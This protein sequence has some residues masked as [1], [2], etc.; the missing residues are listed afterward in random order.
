V[1]LEILGAIPCLLLPG[2]KEIAAGKE[3]WEVVCE[4]DLTENKPNG[5]KLFG[6]CLQLCEMIT[7]EPFG[8]LFFKEGEKTHT[9]E[10]WLVKAKGTFSKDAIIDD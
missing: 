7:E 3:E 2:L 5:D 6:T 10:A 8:A 4:T 1:K 9:D